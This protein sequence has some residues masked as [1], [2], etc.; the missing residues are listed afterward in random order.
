MRM[1]SP[2]TNWARVAL[3]AEGVGRN[4]QRYKETLEDLKSPSSRR[5]WVEIDDW[6]VDKA[7]PRV[8]LLAEGV[9]RN[10]AHRKEPDTQ[11]QVALLAEGVGRNDSLDAGRGPQTTVALLAEGVGRNLI[12]VTIILDR[13]RRP[14][15]GGRG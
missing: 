7:R 12:V 11:G 14:P 3:L 1:T 15:R 9:G 10:R 5:A 6:A 13:R 4:K 8:A 2:R